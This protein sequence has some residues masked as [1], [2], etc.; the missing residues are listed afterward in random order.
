[1]CQKLTVMFYLKNRDGWINFRANNNGNYKN[2]LT[3]MCRELALMS[4]FAINSLGVIL[5]MLRK[6]L[7][8]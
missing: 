5:Y 2:G 8:K 6:L 4:H 3:V 1:M 7:V